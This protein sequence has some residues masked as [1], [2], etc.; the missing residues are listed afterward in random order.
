[1]FHEPISPSDES[2]PQP[3]ETEWSD[4]DADDT[5]EDSIDSICPLGCCDYSFYSILDC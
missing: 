5:R 1:M 4:E 2:D 3:V